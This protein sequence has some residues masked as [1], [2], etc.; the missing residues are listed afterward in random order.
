MYFSAL[1]VNSKNPCPGLHELDLRQQ[2]NST[3]IIQ[4]E[5]R[6]TCVEVFEFLLSSFLFYM[7]QS[8]LQQLPLHCFVD[9][10]VRSLGCAVQLPILPSPTDLPVCLCGELPVMDSKV[11]VPSFRVKH[12]KAINMN[13]QFNHPEAT[14]NNSNARFGLGQ[15]SIPFPIWLRAAFNPPNSIP[16]DLDLERS[17]R[18][19]YWHL[20]RGRRPTSSSWKGRGLGSSRSDGLSAW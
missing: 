20:A 8:R 19:H 11:K 3:I 12:W 1:N 10:D 17:L 4:D 2:V 7:D 15:P 9:I 6:L 14:L 16:G 18:C 5:N 13:L